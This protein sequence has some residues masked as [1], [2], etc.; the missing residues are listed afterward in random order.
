MPGRSHCRVWASAPLVAHGRCTSPCSAPTLHHQ[1]EADARAGRLETSW[2][3]DP[4]TGSAACRSHQ[5]QSACNHACSARVSSAPHS[6][7]RSVGGRSACIACR[8]RDVPRR[9]GVVIWHRSNEGNQVCP[10]ARWCTRSWA[11]VLLTCSCGDAAVPLRAMAAPQHAPSAP[12]TRRRRRSGAHAASALPTRTGVSANSATTSADR[13]SNGFPA[14]LHRVF[15]ALL[16]T[17]G[18]FRAARFVP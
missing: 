15:G 4:P 7:N 8:C 11:N 1:G 10:A 3:I 9:R 16:A 12:V 14:T 17:I 18:N 5:W 2:W 6:I 13:W